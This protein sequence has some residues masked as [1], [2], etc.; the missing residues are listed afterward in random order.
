MRRRDSVRRT[1]RSQRFT[2]R[3]AGGV[4]EGSGAVISNQTLEFGGLTL[5][6][7]GGSK[8]LD[9]NGNE[10]DM[11]SF[12]GIVSGD[13]TGWV[14]S[15]GR[16]LRNTGTPASSDG[17]IFLVTT[18]VGQIQVTIQSSGM[19][20]E[21]RDLATAYHYVSDA[22]RAALHALGVATLSGKSA[23]ARSNTYSWVNS[24][25]DNKAYTSTFYH[26]AQFFDDSSIIL[27][28]AR[29]F[30]DPEL[31]TIEGFN[32]RYEH[33]PGTTS[34]L[35]DG[36][37]ISGTPNGLR[38]S[39]CLHSTNVREIGFVTI[40]RGA[41]NLLPSS[42][43]GPLG[44][45]I[46][47]CRFQGCLRGIMAPRNPSDN[48][49]T[50]RRPI[51][52]DYG[53]D[54][55]IFSDGGPVVYNDL[56]MYD[57]WS[58]PEEADFVAG[59][60]I[61]YLSRVGG[62][63]GAVDS[64]TG[65]FF[66][67]V[68]IK[69]PNN[70]NDQNR[71]VFKDGALQI[72]F[73]TLDKL[74]VTCND[75]G[76]AQVVNLTSATTYN[77]FTEEWLGILL[78][79]DTSGTHRLYVSTNASNIWVSEASQLGTGTTLDFTGGDT[80][81]NND[82]AA[83]IS[84][85]MGVRRIAW[86]PAVTTD[87]TLEATQDLFVDFNVPSYRTD[88]ATAVT[89]LGTPILDLT[90]LSQI[91][92]GTNGGSGGDLAVTGRIEQDHPDAMQGIPNADAGPITL[93]RSIVFDKRVG[94]NGFD[95]TI[96]NSGD[97]RG[98]IQNGFF[99]DIPN[100]LYTLVRMI[101]GIVF[102]A[103]PQGFEVYNS[104]SG[105]GG[106]LSFILNTEK[107][108]DSS[109][110][111]LQPRARFL[112]STGGG[113]VNNS[114]ADCFTGP[115]SGADL[116][117]TNN[118]NPDTTDIATYLADLETVFNWPWITTQP[119]TYQELLTAIT[120]RVGAALATPFP[121]IGAVTLAG[122]NDYVNHTTDHPRFN[123][124]TVSPFTDVVDVEVATLVTSDLQ[125]VSAVANGL[126]GGASVQGALFRVSG[127]NAPE[128]QVT[129][130]AAGL[131]PVFDWRSA[132]AVIKTGQYGRLRDVSSGSNST[133]TSVDVLFGTVSDTWTIT[134]ESGT[135]P[136]IKEG[137][138]S[139]GDS[140]FSSGQEFLIPVETQI[141]D[142]ITVVMKHPGN[143]F[144]VTDA[145]DNRGWTVIVTDNTGSVRTTFFVKV[146]DAQDVIDAGAGTPKVVLTIGNSLSAANATA[147]SNY[148]GISGVEATLAAIPA[149][150]T[151]PQ[152]TPSTGA[153][154][155]VFQTTLAFA[156]S[157]NSITGAPTNYID[158]T[159]GATN[160]SNSSGAV[161]IATAYRTLIDATTDTPGPFTTAGSRE[162]E[163]GVTASIK[164][165]DVPAP[166]GD[167]DSDFD[168]DHA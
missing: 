164:G 146:A 132:P 139:S 16:L 148:S 124:P 41:I 126:E 90:T 72:W 117:D 65:T 75:T 127:G 125:L 131:I 51:M 134:T 97:Y 32:F 161:R 15:G 25:W 1:R 118:Y 71:I 56:L 76:L 85:A 36:I 47:D 84:T 64:T 23:L 2:N 7:A 154:D 111:S 31:I 130:D 33:V 116:L 18:T 162:N 19:D 43:T 3:S 110:S 91:A 67:L 144:N 86:W 112:N 12:D 147:Y 94:T 5:T 11:V 24:E 82:P 135:G 155:Y 113:S 20:S 145:E 114:I 14:V 129:S 81:I 142:L 122:Y 54:G 93:F 152:H 78:S 143:N 46:D 109:A 17:A 166:L 98:F 48:P 168:S 89:A 22:E 103:R 21:G 39:K 29:S 107:A 69:N 163:V 61:S 150:V 62:F 101:G 35:N 30:D 119:N 59:G 70:G 27:V 96:Y 44:V 105:F 53:I 100:F 120:P 57:P 153:A 37:N 99:E 87:P 28:N 42:D 79:L 49:L 133:L 6:A 136:P 138:I 156:R 157:N 58:N 10:I 80:S 52:T 88:P 77:G 151:P 4:E 167:F 66:A 45:E 26:G 104:V 141:G 40:C 9:D 83:P 108:S 8:A 74:R 63:S 106:A 38:F 115:Q 149:G 73:D 160:S 50:V 137:E 158:L 128:L 159:V 95:G 140:I 68:N 13:G 60:N 102:C 55:V 121:E 92:N 123:T 34:Q 165:P